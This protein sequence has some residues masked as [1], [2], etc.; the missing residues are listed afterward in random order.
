MT[1]SS[2]VHRGEAASNFS[3]TL[4]LVVVPLFFFFFFLFLLHIADRKGNI[5]GRRRER[6]LH[7]V[8]S[9]ASHA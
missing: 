3:V 4:A 9:N 2:Q 6:V 5:E 8:Y 7:V 1:A